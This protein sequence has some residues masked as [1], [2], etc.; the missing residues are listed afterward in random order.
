MSHFRKKFKLR[1]IIWINRITG[2]IIIIIGLVLL[3][4][5]L[6]RILFRGAEFF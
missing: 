2:A 5:W 3:G 1:T 6:F 4:E